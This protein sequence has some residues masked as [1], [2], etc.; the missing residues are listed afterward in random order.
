M[1]LAGY[2]INVLTLSALAIAFGLLVDG[3]VVVMEAI[4]YRR[5]R[6]M[7]PLEAAAAGAREV[8]M[9]IL[10][11]I[12]TTLVAFV[13]LLASEGSFASTTGP[14]PSPLPPP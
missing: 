5:R 4:A 13:P 8:A 10:G 1:F 2:S 9:P 3:A 14:S 11:G 6:G 7:P 12:L